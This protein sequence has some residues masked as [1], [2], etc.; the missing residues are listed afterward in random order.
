MR[1][2]ETVGEEAHEEASSVSGIEEPQTRG[3]ADRLVEE[4]VSGG[5]DLPLPG[6]G[7]T[8]SRWE[9]LQTLAREDLSLARLA[10]GHTDALAIL[11]ELGGPAAGP[12]EVWG[13]WAAHPPAA[14]LKAEQSGGRWTVHG[15]KPFCSGARV[16]TNALVS[17]DVEEGERA[18]FAV[19]TAG[20][21]PQ[22]GTWA[23]AGMAASDTLT[24]R[25]AGQRAEPVGRPGDYVDRPGFH[26]GGAGVAACWYGGALAVAR[27]LADRADGDGADPHLLAAFGE[28]DRDLYI[29]ETVLRRAAREIDENPGARTAALAA[30]VR[31]VVA[32]TCARVLR[33]AGEALGAGP[34]AGDPSF[35]RATADLAVYVRQHH[36]NRDLAALGVLA[37][38]RWR[39]EADDH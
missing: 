35:A 27:P 1:A 23:S 2:S 7:A 9:R 15:A 26:H 19:R 36:G 31:A 18:L 11:A 20:T 39:R 30:R 17:A 25:F 12:G 32:D 24:V 3:V 14:T 37:A 34:L 10:E 4:V 28:V 22:S 16:C 33:R 5:L 6:S 13:V 29:S 8:W 38:D 21:D